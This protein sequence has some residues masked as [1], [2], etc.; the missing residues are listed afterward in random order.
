M[1]E[2]WMRGRVRERL[3]LGHDDPAPFHNVTALP[4]PGLATREVFGAL[5]GD[6]PVAIRLRSNQVANGRKAFLFDPA[7]A[8]VDVGVIISS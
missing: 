4:H 3:A 7:P 1:A 5:Y 6:M 8:C 2:V